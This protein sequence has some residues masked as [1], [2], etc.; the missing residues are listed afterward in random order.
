MWKTMDELCRK[1][2]YPHKS[3]FELLGLEPGS[4]WKETVRDVKEKRPMKCKGSKTQMTIPKAVNKLMLEHHP[5]KNQGEQGPKYQEVNYFKQL[6]VENPDVF[7]VVLGC[8]LYSKPNP[9][10]QNKAERTT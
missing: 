5:D 2:P 10:G 8:R 6:L 3:P 7:E 1:F 4:D 9:S